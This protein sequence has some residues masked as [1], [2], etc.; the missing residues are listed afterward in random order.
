MGLGSDGLFREGLED[1]VG[2]RGQWAI[3]VEGGPGEGAGVGAD[4]ELS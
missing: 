3:P 4:G 2:L 1:S